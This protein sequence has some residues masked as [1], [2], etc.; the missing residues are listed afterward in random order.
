MWAIELSHLSILSTSLPSTQITSFRSLL[1]LPLF[2][3]TLYYSSFSY[4]LNSWTG[5]FHIQHVRHTTVHWGVERKKT[6]LVLFLAPCMQRFLLREGLTRANWHR[7][8]FLYLPRCTSSCK[9]KTSRNDKIRKLR[10]VHFE[11]LVHSFVT[12]PWCPFFC[13]ISTWWIDEG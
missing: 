9:T 1:L 7:C 5:S 10:F 3:H 6:V 8:A 12:C 4:I 13:S 2:T 11:V